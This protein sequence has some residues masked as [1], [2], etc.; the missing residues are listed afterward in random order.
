MWRRTW[1]R[2]NYWLAVWRL[3]TGRTRG[4]FV[5]PHE[6]ERMTVAGFDPSHPGDEFESPVG[7]WTI[8]ASQRVE[9]RPTPSDAEV[10]GLAS[11][12]RVK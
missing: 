7:G 3:A 8:W 6:G 9:Y 11:I 4:F 1:K 10:S 5:Y 2:I 12:R